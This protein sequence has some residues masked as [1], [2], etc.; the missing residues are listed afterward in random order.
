MSDGSEV[1][2]LLVEIRDNQ[3]LALARQEEQLAIAREQVERSRTQVQES[4]QLQR[5]AAA[6]VARISLFVIP[7][8]LVC[9]VL[10]VY[11]VVRY[12]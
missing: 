1:R 4:I 8:V 6:R 3:R 9:L 11:L 12:L 5:Q 10:I 7:L 2:D